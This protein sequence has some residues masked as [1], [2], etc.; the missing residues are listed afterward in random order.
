[1][2]RD[3]DRCFLRQLGL[4]SIQEI[5]R[6]LLRGV[7]DVGLVENVATVLVA[8]VSPLELRGGMA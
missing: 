5:E 1:M 6:A 7:V 8:G 3:C 4:A 2:H